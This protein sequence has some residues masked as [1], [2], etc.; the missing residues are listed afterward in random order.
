[1]NVYSSILSGWRDTRVPQSRLKIRHVLATTDLSNESIA[2]VRYAVA[3]AEKMSGAV[4][5]LHIVDF[6]P[7]QPMPGIR[8]ATESLQYSKIAKYSR[9][10]LKTVAKRESSGDLNVTPI[11]RS[12][13]SFYGI[14]TAARERAVDLIV[15]ATHGHTGAKRVLLGSTTERVVRHAP[16]PVLTVPARTSRRRAGKTPSLNLKRILVPIDFSKTSKTAFP[17]AASVAAQFNA[18]L[19]LLH[20]VE[21]FPAN[22]LLGR[23]LLNETITPLI[24]ERESDLKWMAKS[25]SKST[26]LKVSAV[27]RAGKP[28]KEICNAARKLG[29]DLITLTTRG[30]TGLK[31]VWLGST[32]ERVVRHASCPVLAVR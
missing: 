31:R 4:A 15:I 13:N 26:G 1:M 32:A 27:V 9:I 3:L 22:Y 8:T 7:P 24:K 18:S 19:I 29:A 28:F 12:G 14:I 30:H 11:L 17:W 21:T 5:L 25:L 2:G 16:C 23:E 20:V 6:P 10:R